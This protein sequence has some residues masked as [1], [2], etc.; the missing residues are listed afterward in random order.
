MGIVGLGQRLAE[1]TTCPFARRSTSTRFCSAIFSM[2]YGCDMACS[3]WLLWA[4]LSG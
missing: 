4:P 2:K 1:R 3:S